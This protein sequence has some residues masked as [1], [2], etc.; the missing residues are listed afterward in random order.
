MTI[1]KKDYEW[2]RSAVFY[3]VLVRAF[4]DSDNNG[5]GDL[6]GLTEKLDYLQWLGVDCLWLP[7]FYD[8]PLRDGG[9]D[10]RDF[11]AVLDEFGTVEDFKVLLDEAHARGIRVITDLVM[12]HTSDSHEWFQQSRTD[13]DGPYGDFYVWTDDP[14]TYSGARIIFVDTEDSNW[15]YDPVRGQYYWH[16]FFSHQPDLNYDNPAVQEAMLDVL[17]F[18]SDLGIDGFRLDAVPY[19]FER[20]GTNCENL[21]ETHAFLKRCRKVMDEE[22]PGRVLLAEANQWPSDVVEYFG[23][24]EVGGDECH[25]AFHFPLMPRIFMAVR[26]QSRFPISEILESTPEIPSSAQWGI[27][28]RNHD[29]LTLEMVTDAER[30]YMYAEYAH[31]PRMKANIGIRR[32]LAPLLQNDRTQLELFNA[33]LL[34]LPGSPVLYYGD[35][36]G[37]GDNIWLGDRDGVRTPMQWSP[38]RNAGFSKADPGRLYLPT[39]QDATYGYQAVNV[40]NQASY[41]NSL[42]NWVRRLIQVRK[43]YEAFGLGDFR[44]LNSDTA[45]VLTYLRT[46]GDEVLLCVNNLSSYPAAVSLD[47]SEFAGATP[48]ELTGSVPFPTIGT[49]SYQI[50][51]PGHGFY[52]FEIQLPPETNAESSVSMSAPTIPV[53]QAISDAPVTSS[54]EPS[55]TA[56]DAVTNADNKE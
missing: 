24:P 4:F 12:N 2:Y 52:W 40:E 54:R 55:G 28:L 56:A 22:Y 44:E 17:R 21:P 33:L 19:L 6:K 9:Y 43:R 26:K 53:A 48:V 16:R 29:E 50:T 34:S 18:W 8:S 10:I 23:D 42:L 41:S 5:S 3:E 46:Y 13:P 27:F 30:D 15:T 39:I 35:E 51:L 20:E 36:I 1:A 7:P 37:M 32:R 49:D 25:M 31:D 14:D 47:L 45:S 38:D 11:R